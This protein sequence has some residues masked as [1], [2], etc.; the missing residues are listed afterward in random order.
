MKNITRLAH[1]AACMTG[2]AIIVGL[3]GCVL[4]VTNCFTP[5]IGKLFIVWI[6]LA[7]TAYQLEGE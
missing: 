5:H 4:H 1:T 6:G 2:A 3:I 7:V